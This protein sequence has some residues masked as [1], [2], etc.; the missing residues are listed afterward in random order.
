MGEAALQVVYVQKLVDTRVCHAPLKGL[1]PH[2]PESHIEIACP[3]T[4]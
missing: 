4:F 1:F 2:F 3:A